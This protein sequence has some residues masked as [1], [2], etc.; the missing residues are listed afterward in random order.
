MKKKQL[1]ILLLLVALTTAGCQKEP[2]ASFVTNASE[3]IA[4][5]IVH[6]TNTSGNADSYIWAMPDGRK[7]TT[8]N[9]DYQIDSNYGFGTLTFI[10]EAFSKNGSK[11][12]SATRSVDIIPASTFAVDSTNFSY[13]PLNVISKAF[14]NNWAIYGY[15]G[16]TQFPGLTYSIADG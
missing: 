10:L 5:D 1:F 9:A 16:L 3:Y 12:S 8:T 14:G 2:E 13:H 11:T 7:L 4:G 6:L 15:T